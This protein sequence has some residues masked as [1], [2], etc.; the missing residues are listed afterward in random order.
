M[1]NPQLEDGYTSIANEILERLALIKISPA[2]WRVLVTIIRRTYGFHKKVDWIANF[3]IVKSTGLCKAVVSRSL[4]RLKK[5]NLILRN[6]KTIGFQKDWEK[7]RMLAVLQTSE[8]KEPPKMRIV[9]NDGYIGIWRAAI[10]PEFRSMATKQGYILEHRLVMAQSLGRCLELWEV[11]HHKGTKF[12]LGSLEDKGDNRVDN[13]ELLPTQTEHMPSILMQGGIKQLET[14][15]AESQTKVDDKLAISPSTVAKQ[16]T[17][18]SSCA[19]TQKI[20]DNKQKIKDKEFLSEKS[21]SLTLAKDLNELKNEAYELPNKKRKVAF[22]I[23]VFRAYHSKAPPDDLENL[24]GRIAGIL[25]S[26]SYDYGY[27]LGLIWDSRS[28]NISGSHLNYI[29]GMIK[30][31]NGVRLEDSGYY[32]HLEEDNGYKRKTP[33]PQH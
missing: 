24:G 9:R 19:V 8:P 18:V 5:N 10:E 15:L 3:Q 4:A 25:K 2:D 27:L 32:K 12:P 14:E 13:L 31:R 16:S 23:D 30:G 1:A 6:G 20:K 22:L 26:I 7:W 21:I 33:T 11:V 17:K 28:I 29:Q